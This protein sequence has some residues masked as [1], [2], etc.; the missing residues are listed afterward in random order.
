MITRRASVSAAALLASVCVCVAAERPRRSAPAKP[1]TPSTRPAVDYLVDLLDRY[2][3]GQQ[4][5]AFFAAAGV[6]G[7]L[8]EAEWKAAAGKPNTFVRPYDRWAAALACDKDR[9]SKL[10][11]PEAD[12]YR[13]QIRSR[14]L[15]MFD[16]SKDGKL[17]G[18]ER[19]PANAYL[20][21]G[22]P[23]ASRGGPMMGRTGRGS[24]WGQYD[25]NGD[26]KLDDAERQAMQQAW[27]KR[28]EQA[29][30][31]YDL[32][33][34][35][36]DKDGQLSDQER[37][38]KQQA[39][40]QQRARAEKYRKD[41]LAKYDTD[42]D[43]K[44]SD[45]ERR[46]AYEKQRAERQRKR[47]EQWDANGDGEIK[48]EEAEAE[49]DHYR[50]EAQRRRQEWMVKRH[51]KDGDGQLDEQEQAAME[52][53]QAKWR[54]YRER[55]QQRAREFTKQWDSDGDG[56]ISDGERTEM[57]RSLRVEAERRR[58]EMDTDGDGKVSSDE[59]K[60]YWNQLRQKYDADG[61]GELNADERQKMIREQ[62]N[63]V[64]PRMR[65]R[66]GRR[67]SMVPLP[68]GPGETTYTSQDGSVRM[69]VRRR[70]R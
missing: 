6:D 49:R 25:A 33:R 28:S 69:I 36:A 62:M 13:E 41:M 12:K 59:M 14:L 5:D 55:A 4:R 20:A 40:A 9:D 3:Q 43:G 7:Q 21:K 39:E 15:S 63:S 67:S 60:A 42:G 23:A 50:K 47:L 29:R 46:S 35:D 56:K 58:K 31:A 37:S 27:R 26:G 64:M 22:M 68:T 45:Q 1:R 70:Q 65:G 11:W 16:K 44:V 57:V 32:R 10:S 48:G 30:R 18:A 38:A 53:E 54:Q 34:Y 24:A 51:D 2:V 19:P 8:T 61:D 17:T 52:A 66:P